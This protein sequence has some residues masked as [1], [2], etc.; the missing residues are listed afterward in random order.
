MKK[1]KK[2][3]VKTLNKLKNDDF[4]NEMM[5]G[6]LNKISIQVHFKVK[7][8]TVSDLR[9]FKLFRKK[10]NSTFIFYFSKNLC[11]TPGDPSE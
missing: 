4:N 6:I 2:V 9:V 1:K 8:C 7:T 3:N 5:A 11:R 10:I